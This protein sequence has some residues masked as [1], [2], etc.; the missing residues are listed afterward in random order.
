MMHEG[1]VGLTPLP[2]ADGR[3]KPRPAILLRRMPPFGDWLSCGV[4]SQIHQQVVGFDDVIQMADADFVGSGLKAPS[5]VRLGFLTT[6]P[7]DRFLGVL[8]S[9]S[10]DRHLRLLDR[11]S[12]FLALDQ[13]SPR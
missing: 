12:R 2:Q 7:A 3:I 1:G 11:L 13:S 6:M 8:G 4:S 9:I 10:R 5:V